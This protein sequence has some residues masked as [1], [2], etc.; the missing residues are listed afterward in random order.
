MAKRLKFDPFAQKQKY[1][2]QKSAG[3]KLKI[4]CGTFL[5]AVSEVMVQYKN[6]PF[7]NLSSNEIEL[8]LVCIFGLRGVSALKTA[9][10][11]VPNQLSTD[12][13]I[14]YMANIVGV[15]VDPAS[16]FDTSNI[17]RSFLPHSTKVAYFH[18]D[19][20]G[21]EV[22]R[23]ASYATGIAHTAILAPPVSSC[24]C[25]QCS[26]LGRPLYRHHSPTTVTIFTLNGPIPGTKIN[27]KCSDCSTIYNYCMYG[28]K[29]NNGEQFYDGCLRKYLEISDEV[30][31]ERSLFELYCQ[32]RYFINKLCLCLC[33][34]V[35]CFLC[36][37]ACTLGLASMGLVK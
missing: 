33:N 34:N 18:H 3:G 9:M 19:I 10:D 7:E 22:L 13:Q 1:N 36:C 25:T 20:N 32:L 17:I 8:V 27:L 23:N 21:T 16:K 24:I 26:S 6:L 5:N 15:V 29:A 30:Y 35:S 37:T 31:C 4:A 14:H 2:L 11:V 12:H 28:Q